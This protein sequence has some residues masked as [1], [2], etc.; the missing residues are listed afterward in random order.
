MTSKLFY[1]DNLDVLLEHISG[2]SAPK[3]QAAGRQERLI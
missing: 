3:R 2:E 1:G